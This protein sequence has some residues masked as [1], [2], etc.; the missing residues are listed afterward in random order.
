[1]D[2]LSNRNRLV[3]PNAKAAM[4]SLKYEVAHDLGLDDDIK[5][6]GYAEMTTR[7]VGKIGG[8]MV[9]KMIEIAEDQLANN[10]NNNAQK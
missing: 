7:E 3:N 5:E 8:N 1:M 4:E 9:K 10:Q 6:R 2:I